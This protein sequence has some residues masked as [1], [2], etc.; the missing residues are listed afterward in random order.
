MEQEDQ[1]HR[2]QEEDL[3]QVRIRR[4]KR[5]HREEYRDPQEREESQHRHQG[6]QKH[7][8]GTENQ[9]RCCGP[10]QKI[11]RQP[12]PASEEKTIED[13]E[14]EPDDAEIERGGGRSK[15]M[16]TRR[17]RIKHDLRCQNHDRRP[18]ALVVVEGVEQDIGH[19]H[20]AAEQRNDIGHHHPPT[21]MRRITRSAAACEQAR[22]RQGLAGTGAVL[23]T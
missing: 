9:H 10:R 18:Q 19:R 5:R 1:R 13:S 12:R 7:A 4:R 15:P 8:L 16:E 6:R 21:H 20:Q 3:D 2:H 14:S 22:H 23:P 11:E 17:D